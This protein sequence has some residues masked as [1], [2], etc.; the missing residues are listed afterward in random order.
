MTHDDAQHQYVSGQVRDTFPALLA[1]FEAM[2]AV[3]VEHGD[4][5][6]DIR[7]GER[8]RETFDLFQAQ[9]DPRGMLAYFHA[10]YW[11]SRDKSTF[12]WLAPMLTRRGLHVAFVNYPLCPSV[13]LQGLVDAVA[14]S[15]PHVTAHAAR[16]GGD[17]RPLIACGHSAGGHL[18]VELALAGHADGVIALSGIYDLAPLLATTLNDKLGLDDSTARALSPLHRVR[19]G[20]PPALFVVG[21]DETSGF[22]EQTRRMSEAWQAAGNDT[23]ARVVPG[24]DHFSLL[25][26]FAAPESE[27]AEDVDA[28]IEKA[29][30]RFFS[31][32]S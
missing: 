16:L 28:L 10:G 31:S 3:V 18:A 19:A 13:T 21:G 24:A 12:R 7:Y 29:R 9:G 5:E 32:N 4:C 8:P 30:Q 15:V 14:A 25:S 27:L 23:E 1:D 2:S 22:V 6:L 11:Q 26:M 20:T 17:A